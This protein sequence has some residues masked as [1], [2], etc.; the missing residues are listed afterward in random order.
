[1]IRPETDDL[2]TKIETLQCVLYVIFA[3]KNGNMVS[4]L[5]TIFIHSRS[6]TTKAPKVGEVYPICTHQKI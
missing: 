6:G 4:D 2:W 3:I 1:M 5:K